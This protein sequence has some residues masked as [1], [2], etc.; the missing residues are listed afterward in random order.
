M[1]EVDQQVIERL[2]AVLSAPNPPRY[3]PPSADKKWAAGDIAATIPV[4]DLPRVAE[5]LQE[6]GVTITAGVLKSYAQV[7]RAYPSHQRNVR[8]AWAVY[9]EARDVPPEQRSSVLW[10]GQT[11]RGVRLALGKGPMDQPRRERQPVE[12]RAFAV[13]QELQD[14]QVREL[15]M[16]EMNSSAADRKAR[17]AAKTTLDEIA[18]RQKLIDAELRKRKQEGTPESQFWRAS[19]ELNNA[20]KFIYSVARLYSRHPD[21]MEEYRWKELVEILRSVTNAAADAAD[22]L[23][24][25]SDDEFIE[26]EALDNMFE[27]DAGEIVDAEIVDDGEEDHR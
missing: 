8:A 1:A 27:L 23:E 14:P 15:V 26:G 22:R 9:R 18:A 19:K 16:R 11:L 2:G 12:D 24:G 3:A 10:D 17:R 25:S 21:A 7:A 4:P 13:T 20:A 5:R 6:R